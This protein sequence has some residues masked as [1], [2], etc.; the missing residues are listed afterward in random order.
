MGLPP[1]VWTREQVAAR[2]LAGETLVIVDNQVVRVPQ[3]W[4]TAHPGGVLAVL[5]FVG[6]DA[7]DEVHAFHSVET[8]KRMQGYVIGRIQTD[9]DGWDPL[10]PPIMSGWV[11]KPGKDDKMEWY[12]EAKPLHPS[13]NFPSV[14][15]SEMLLVERDECSSHG[16]S[17]ADLQHPETP[18]SIELQM[19]H[20]R[21]YTDLHQRVKDA[22]LYNTPY[23][24]GYGPEFIRYTLLGTLSAIL[25]MKGWL[26]PS[27]FFLGL[28]WQQLT[29]FVHD[30]GHLGVTHNWV[31]DRLTAIFFADFIGGLSVGWWVNNHN[32]HHL[33]TNHP[34]HDPDIQHL[35]FFAITPV[36]FQSLWSTYY[37]RVLTFD[38]FAKIFI[39]LQHKLFYVVLSLARFNLYALSYGYL[40][41]TAFEPRRAIGGRWWWWTEIFCL[42]LYY[43]WYIAVLRGCG[44]W[45]NILTYLLVSHIAA[46]PVHVQI[47]L[48]HFS[49]STEDVGVTESFFAR[50]LR[51]TVDVICSPRIEF[52]HGGLHLQVTHHLFPR[53]PRHNLRKASL[54]VKEHAKELGLEYAEFGFVEGN[55]DVR[56]VLKSVGDQL[57]IV[58]MVADAN[59]Q[60]AIKGS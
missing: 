46:C 33:V 40:A 45:G 38:I 58:G 12:N 16:P 50:Q 36:F 51:T 35:P 22:G 20:S 34:T 26:I 31:V 9:G 17:L 23:I 52:I 37:K 29:F 56:G 48:S 4:L 15:A 28:M 11:R 5:H 55:A 60:D 14:S 49:R 2:I 7:S 1:P 32:I 43:C 27:A 3:S 54:I 13:K 18:L 47:V 59:I 24:K 30:L 41:K 19:R 57:K 6:R 42:G 25:Y 21:A 44:S 8:L 10:L 53:L 39:P